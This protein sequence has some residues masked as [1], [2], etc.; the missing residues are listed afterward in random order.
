MKVFA[1]LKDSEIRQITGNIDV[2]EDCENPMVVVFVDREG[3]KSF[4]TA[5]RVF[6]PS[7]LVR[8]K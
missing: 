5:R 1:E 6:V 3:R 7:D 8:K 2:V 4:R